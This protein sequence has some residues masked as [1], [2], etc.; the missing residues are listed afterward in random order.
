MGLTATGGLL[1]LALVKSY[2]TTLRAASDALSLDDDHML[3]LT[4]TEENII[5]ER[6]TNI[7]YQK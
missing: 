7:I 6:R 4:F 2:L 3:T 5:L 1:L